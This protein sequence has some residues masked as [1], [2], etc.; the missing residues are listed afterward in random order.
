[1]DGCLPRFLPALVQ[2]RVYL[3]KVGAFYVEVGVLICSKAL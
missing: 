2:N 3:S 1:M